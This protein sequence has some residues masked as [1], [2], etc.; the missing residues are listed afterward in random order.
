MV[1]AGVCCYDGGKARPIQQP[2]PYWECRSTASVPDGPLQGVVADNH[3]TAP[4]DWIQL[5]RGELENGATDLFS[6]L[7][8]R[9]RGSWVR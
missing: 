9:V 6:V 5:G 4:E 2:K 1:W 3:N 8:S 7:W